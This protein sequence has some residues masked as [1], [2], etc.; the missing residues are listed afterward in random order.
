MGWN[1]KGRQRGA[2]I[3]NSVG[4]GS[5]EDCF[6]WEH[7]LWGIGKS[8]ERPKVGHREESE[9]GA[10]W[11]WAREVCDGVREVG[12]AGPVG[13]CKE[14]GLYSE[15]N[16]KPLKGYCQ[17]TGTISFVFKDLSGCGVEN[18]CAIIVSDGLRS[19][20]RHSTRPPFPPSLPS[21]AVLHF[22]A[23]VFC[24][25]FACMSLLPPCTT[26]SPAG[27]LP[28]AFLDISSKANSSMNRMTI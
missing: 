19:A 11:A 4:R 18:I 13:P 23:L 8:C 17:R 12:K 2:G 27:K 16:G 14:F 3:D 28:L 20:C 1:Y 21:W 26:H 9:A 10:Q 6:R 25:P 7:F 15:S 5:G 24:I 22:L